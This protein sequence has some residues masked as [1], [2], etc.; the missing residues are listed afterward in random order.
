MDCPV[1]KVSEVCEEAL[2]MG[3]TLCLNCLNAKLQGLEEAW[4]EE[5]LEG[6]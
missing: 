1:C 3:L 4:A 5:A 2:D 6:L